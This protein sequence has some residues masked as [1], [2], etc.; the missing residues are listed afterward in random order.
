MKRKWI[1]GLLTLLMLIVTI[2][3]V[4]INATDDCSWTCL[5]GNS[6]RT[7]FIENK[8]E[9][10]IDN[11]GIFWTRKVDS[12]IQ[13]SPVT[14]DDS[15]YITNIAGMVYKFDIATSSMIWRKDLGEE[16]ASTPCL[17]ERKMIVCTYS[18]PSKVFCLDI[19]TGGIIWVKEMGGPI[20]S[21]PL[22]EDKKVYLATELAVISCLDLN[23]GSMLWSRV[24]GNMIN[25]SPCT[26]DTGIIFCDNNSQIYCLDYESGTVVWSKRFTS[27]IAVAPTYSF[28]HIYLNLE[29]G[30]IAC[31][32]SRDGNEVEWFKKIDIGFNSSPAVTDFHLITASTDGSVHCIRKE[33]GIKLWEVQLDV[34]SIS[35]SPIIINRHIFITD[36]SGQLYILN[37]A[38]KGETIWKLYVD[39]KIRTSPATSFGKIYLGTS[40]GKIICLGKKS[41]PG[42]EPIPEPDPPIAG[43]DIVMHGKNIG[44]V[45]KRCGYKPV[46]TH[47]GNVFVTYQYENNPYVD[48]PNLFLE[49]LDKKTGEKLWNK[50][51]IVGIDHEDIY[52]YQF[53]ATNGKLYMTTVGDLLSF[54][55]HNTFVR[56]DIATKKRDWMSKAQVHGLDT[57]CPTSLRV[58]EGKVFAGNCGGELFCLDANDGW[59]N[60]SI[61][62]EYAQIYPS[63]LGEYSDNYLYWV[64][65]ELNCNDR[66]TG[67]TLWRF[68]SL[69]PK[70]SG[71]PVKWNTNLIVASRG[72]S[73][74]IINCL[75]R[76]NGKVNWSY[77]TKGYV[78]T[79]RR[80][81]STLIYEEYQNDSEFCDIVGF[82]LEKREEVWRI[83]RERFHIRQGYKYKDLV[84][85]VYYVAGSKGEKSFVTAIDPIDGAILWTFETQEPSNRM[86]I[87]DDYYYMN[88]GGKVFYLEGENCTYCYALTPKGNNNSIID[89][90][91]DPEPEPLPPTDPTPPSDLPDEEVFE[92]NDECGWYMTRG[93]NKLGY[94]SN[95][96]DIIGTNLELAWS[97]K[98]EFVPTQP[99]VANNKV[100]IASKTSRAGS[101]VLLALSAENGNLLTSNKI[102]GTLT[103]PLS[104]SNNAVYMGANDGMFHAISRKDGSEL[105][106]FGYAFHPAFIAP[107][108]VSENRALFVSHFVSSLLT[109][110]RLHCIDPVTGDAIW[111]RDDV[112]PE[113]Q[114]VSKNGMV[115]T[116]DKDNRIICL[117]LYT[118]RL[119]WSSPDNI[120]FG[121]PIISGER[122]FA[123]AKGRRLYCFKTVSGELRWHHR[124]EKNCASPIDYLF[125]QKNK[126]LVLTDNQLLCLDVASGDVVWRLREELDLGNGLMAKGNNIYLSK[127]GQLVIISGEDG[128]ILKETHLA[129]NRITIGDGYIFTTSGRDLLCYRTSSPELPPTGGGS[130]DIGDAVTP[131]TIS[132][133]FQIG[134]KI[135]QVDGSQLVMDVTPQVMFGRT[136]LPARYVLEPLE[137]DVSW[138][139]IEKKVVCELGENVVELWIGKSTAKV[140]GVAVQID[141]NNPD[142]V[143]TII[144]DR[145]MVPMR[146]LAESLGCEV[147]WIADTKEI[148]LT[149]RE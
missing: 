90:D 38:K 83:D 110:D 107:P 16:I 6:A 33:D 134:N 58:V 98:N 139:N 66:I 89:P 39:S 130:D 127:D 63:F 105:W 147:E 73:I 78:D 137:G 84:D 122:V 103:S 61:P 12:N 143:P 72:Y 95:T 118:G 120:Y 27:Q 49:Y 1:S 135:C 112:N 34:S 37:L 45:W 36:D 29:D 94:D 10:D 75:N 55:I 104:L 3:V 4:V 119:L 82:D 88:S 18:S 111:R 23:D 35:N 22:I 132:L 109:I 9:L 7:Q 124:M 117:S 115:F 106:K 57:E 126:L 141:P 80:I 142:I 74:D 131:K 148:I 47:N 125:A 21:S 70:V 46:T 28:K 56:Y 79:I 114:P 48:V 146:F 59:I 136:L 128:E 42:N 77:D 108:T 138:D 133:T 25:T 50:E 85:G 30:S 68:D 2:P 60:W 97:R 17:D 43:D 65:T 11:F 71:N 76:F 96:C 100:Y 44:L 8:C 129:T 20:S 26:S 91:P 113:T 140:N 149:Y 19:G 93:N 13:A 54:T 99:V 51:T 5:G 101:G 145:T 14:S 15:V 116:L 86:I 123:R 53:V 62:L 40:D 69:A 92:E 144:N 41:L 121:Q 102:A 24:A 87:D 67:E 64:S 81:D 32:R 31:I 52:G